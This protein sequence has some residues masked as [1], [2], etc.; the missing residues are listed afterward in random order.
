MK[1]GGKP[2]S[3]PPPRAGDTALTERH[4]AARTAER[5]AVHPSRVGGCADGRGVFSARAKRKRPVRR[6]PGRPK[7]AAGTQLA[8]GVRRPCE[9]TQKLSGRGVGTRRGTL[10]RP[11]LPALR[12]E[13]RRP[14]VFRVEVR[15]SMGAPES[16][17]C[18][19]HFSPGRRAL[20]LDTADRPGTLFPMALNC[21]LPAVSY[22]SCIFFL[23]FMP[24]QTRKTPSHT[25]ACICAEK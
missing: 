10:T 13:V 11:R 14:G 7:R 15:V 12:N 22:Y 25:R 5:L 23:F 19:R 20:R 1:D 16:T 24:P 2:A 8:T 3:G 21:A 4:C 18:R 6:P 9:P 17:R